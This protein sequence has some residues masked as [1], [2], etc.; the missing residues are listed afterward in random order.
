VSRLPNFVESQSRVFAADRSII[1]A[2]SRAS[3]S[4]RV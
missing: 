3:I 2:L 4:S 1:F